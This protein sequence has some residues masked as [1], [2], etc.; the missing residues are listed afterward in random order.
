MQDDENDQADQ[1]GADIFDDNLG[2]DVNLE[3]SLSFV[4]P[5]ALKMRHIVVEQMS[6]NSENK[7]FEN[8]A[9]QNQGAAAVNNDNL[10]IEVKDV[11]DSKGRQNLYRHQSQKCLKSSQQLHQQP[12]DAMG[13]EGDDQQEQQ[14]QENLI[15]PDAAH[16]EDKKQIE[17]VA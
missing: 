15:Q 16:E 12:G 14:R 2:H 5:H 7:V 4:Y 17:D 1:I 10:A 13:N 6:A 11:L 3:K 9:A 8:Q